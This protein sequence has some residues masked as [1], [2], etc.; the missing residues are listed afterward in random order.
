LV[1]SV[2]NQPPKSS[3]GG[4]FGEMQKVK[5]FRFFT[6]FDFLHFLK[7]PPAGDLGGFKILIL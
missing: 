6:I 1:V 2:K 5:V 3:T 4:L 7:S